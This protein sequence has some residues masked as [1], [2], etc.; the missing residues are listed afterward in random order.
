MSRMFANSLNSYRSRKNAG[1]SVDMYDN[2]D[3]AIRSELI[4]SA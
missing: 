3:F 4:C 2:L 1:A